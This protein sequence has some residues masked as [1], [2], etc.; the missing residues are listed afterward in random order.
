MPWFQKGLLG[1]IQNGVRYMAEF[2]VEQKDILPNILYFA[3][4]ALTFYN[5][6]MSKLKS[7]LDRTIRSPYFSIAQLLH[8]L[9]ELDL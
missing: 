2:I 4:K 8:K 6:E 1:E 9:P 7:C 3:I 5:M